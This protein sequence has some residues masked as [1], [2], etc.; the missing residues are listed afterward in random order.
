MKRKDSRVQKQPHD[1]TKLHTPADLRA[2][3]EKEMPVLAEEI[4]QFLIEKV[5]KTGGHLASNLGVVELSLALHRVFDAPN[6]HIIWDVGHQS[7]IHKIITGRA[8]RFDELRKVGGLCGFTNRTESEYDAF[9]A[10]HSST[11]VSAALG[12]ATA[13]KIAGKDA[14]TI[15]IIGDGAFTGGMVHEALNNCAPDLPLIIVLNENEMSISRNTGAFAQYIA[16]IRSSRHYLR[17]KNRTKAVLSRIPL[18]GRGLYA[19][20]K[21]FTRFIKR[22][23]YRSNYFEEL[24]FLYLGPEDGNDY[25]RTERILRQ[26]KER[27][28]AVI[29]HLKTKKGK[30]Y[31]PAENDPSHFHSTRPCQTSP[32]EETFHSVFG[33]ELV[34]LAKEHDKICAIT[35]AMGLGCGLDAFRDAYPERFF[36]VGIAE[37]HAATFAAGMAADGMIPCFAVYSTFLQRAYDS[38]VHDIALQNLPVKLFIDRAGLAH[39]DGA[40]HHGIFD[41][42]F[43]SAIPNLQLYAP[44]CYGTLR[45]MMKDVICTDAPCAV[46]YPNAGEDGRVASLFYPDGDFENYG[47]RSDFATN[48]PKK[49][50]IITY[51]NIIKEALDAKEKA[52]QNGLSV[53]ILLVETLKPYEATAKKIAP[54]ITHN[55]HILFLEEGI[56][57]GGAASLTALALRELM[58]DDFPTDY[59]I[60]AIKDHFASPTEKTNLYRYCGISA[61]DILENLI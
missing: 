54:Y 2:L 57:H 60:L 61:T 48:V 31:L 12:F 46:R 37:E 4:R 38:V 23:L 10:G 47:V 9:G 3:P 8:D 6:D 19:A 45:A 15:A 11:S 7:Y 40:T 56:E 50:V 13:D 52:E 20:T 39:S 32:S 43:L 28:G 21:G 1:L 24:G 29:V 18:I 49:N 30:G 22:R 26:A 41:V 55:T 5:T 33:N 17:T 14:Y 34:S 35:A 36:D 16:K 51:G 53:G 44:A 59:R 27:H 58:K 25:E 42:S